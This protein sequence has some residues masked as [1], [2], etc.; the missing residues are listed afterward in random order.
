MNQDRNNEEN[1]PVILVVDDEL[2]TREGLQKALEPDY[3]VLLAEDGEV[4]LEKVRNHRIDIILADLRMP[5][6]NGMEFIRHVNEQTDAPLVIM[7]TAY[8]SV[9]TAVHAMKVG[10][11]DY[12]SKPVDLDNL[13][14]MITRGLESLRSRRTES[15]AAEKAEY[16][17]VE[18]IV[19]RS[20]EM[21]KVLETVRQVA[22]ARSTILITGESG[23]GKELIANAIHRLGTRREN[24]FVVVHC[25]ALNPNL[26]ES[27]LFG[28]EKGAFT[29]ARERHIGRFEK[30]DGGTLFLDEVAEIDPSTQIK[31]LRVLENRAFERVGGSS[32]V[33][34][35][36]R[37]ITATNRD[38]KHEVDTGRF[39]EDLY[40]R[41]NVVNIAL[42]P[43]RE[44]EADFKPLL[45]TFLMDFARENGKSI[46]GIHPEALRVL[47]AYSWPGNVR[48]LRNCIERMVVMARGTMLTLAD[49]PSDISSAV[50]ASFEHE[51]SSTT[52]DSTDIR[53]P[54]AASAHAGG[55]GE[56]EGF[57]INAQERELIIKALQNNGG[58]RTRAAEKLGI[59]RRT[60]H[61]KIHAYGLQNI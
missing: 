46:E 18:G 25:A 30:A 11:Y 53:A 27:E 10:A 52:G 40:Y 39:R 56:P 2:H 60:L 3:R 8:G 55:E 6:M 37:L 16:G 50:E 28:H 58:N 22:S 12:L 29:G 14:M 5:G 26:L 17:G 35:D 49:V 33:E 32:P 31:L 13:E 48:E 21:N 42:P 1:R 9:Q 44:R 51:D 57:D 61:R 23:T 47:E 15:E 54:L 36:V 4:G 7:L 59:S 19:A 43:L 34:V 41:L 24:P 20:A 38:L 45:D